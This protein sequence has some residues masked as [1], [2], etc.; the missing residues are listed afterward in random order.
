M[1]REAAQN[2]LRVIKAGAMLMEGPPPAIKH[3]PKEQ[4]HVFVPDY[5]SNLTSIQCTDSDDE[6]R[7]PEADKKALRK[8]SQIWEGG[9][10]GDNEPSSGG[11]GIKSILICV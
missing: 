8:Y 2:A 5:E 9:A 7:Q 11:D 6:S 1:R 4:T 3:A 10:R